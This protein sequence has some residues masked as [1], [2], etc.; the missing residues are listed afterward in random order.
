[1]GFFPTVALG[2]GV[3]DAVEAVEVRVGRVVL[4]DLALDPLLVCFLL[5]PLLIQAPH[6]ALPVPSPRPTPEL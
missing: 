4:G 2:L 3:G 5:P 1:M 6:L